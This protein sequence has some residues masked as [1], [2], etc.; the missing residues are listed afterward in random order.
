[1]PLVPKRSPQRNDVFVQSNV[2]PPPGPTVINN[3]QDDKEKREQVERLDKL[4]EQSNRVLLQC[5]T[6]FPFDIFPDTLIVDERKVNIIYKEF[7]LS[8][9][10]HSVL[11]ENIQDVQIEAGALFA[12]LTV[13]PSLYPDT[14][15]SVEYLRKNDAFE[16]RRLIQGIIACKREGIDLSKLDLPEIVD[17]IRAVGSAMAT[18]PRQ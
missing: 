1:M 4:V 16:A 17:K 7:F 18:F 10:V 9:N 3:S 2:S 13:I 6:V 11:I 15:V 12:K 5:Q 8:E 14:M